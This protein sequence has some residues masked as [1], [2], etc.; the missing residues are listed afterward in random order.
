MARLSSKKFTIGIIVVFLVVAGGIGFLIFRAISA[1]SKL[2]KEI[3]GKKTNLQTLQGELDKR[4]RF[5][6][7]KDLANAKKMMGRFKK[8]L[9][10]MKEEEE[11]NLL[12]SI[13][14][15]RLKARIMSLGFERLQSEEKTAVSDVIR[16]KYKMRL[17]GNFRWFLFFLHKLETLEKFIKIDSFKISSSAGY[18]AMWKEMKKIEITLSSYYYSPKEAV[19]PKTP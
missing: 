6:I 1:Q 9:P 8:I 3:S 18:V 17:Q 4:D 19:A 2:N 7:E 10:N 5:K 15:L 12:D 13:A 16:L 11:D 14:T